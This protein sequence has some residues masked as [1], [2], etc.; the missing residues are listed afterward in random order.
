MCSDEKEPLKP[1]SEQTPVID[2][3]KINSTVE[4]DGHQVIAKRG[5]IIGK[6][7]AV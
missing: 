5:D 7:S 6:N 3:N 1:S 4:Y 2:S